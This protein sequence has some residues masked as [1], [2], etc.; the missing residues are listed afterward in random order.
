MGADPRIAD[1]QHLRDSQ[2]KA[3]PIDSANCVNSAK[4]GGGSWR[5]GDGDEWSMS[6]LFGVRAPSPGQPGRSRA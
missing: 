5:C 1:A 2:N 6:R 3:Q 4:R